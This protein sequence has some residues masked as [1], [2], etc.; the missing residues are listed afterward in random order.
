MG[1]VNLSFNILFFS[2]L[3]C[4]VNSDSR[5]SLDL[6]A[7]WRRPKMLSYVNLYLGLINDV[8]DCTFKKEKSVTHLH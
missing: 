2:Y 8:W 3:S 4:V 6:K 5:L 1:H 7:E